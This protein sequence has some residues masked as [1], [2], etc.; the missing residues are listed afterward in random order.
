MPEL[1]WPIMLA[2][3][4]LIRSILTVAAL[5]FL[6]ALL[7]AAA[8]QPAGSKQDNQAP[9]V[10]LLRTVSRLVQISVIATDKSGHPVGDLTSADFVVL[11]NGRREDIRL[12]LEKT[13][14]P[15]TDPAPALPPD[16]YTDR[17]QDVAGIPPS[18][19]ML[20]LDGI[21]T[22]TSDQAYA[23]QQVIKFLQQ[24]KGRDRLAIF[25][26]GRDLHVLQD[27]TDDS[28]KLAAALGKYSGQ[29]TM[30]LEASTPTQLQ[31]GNDSIDA[32]LQ[33]AFQREANMYIQ[34][35]VRVTVAAL[36]EIA[37]HAAALPGRKNLLWVSGSF[38]FSVEYENLQEIARIVNDSNSESNLPGEQ[39]LFV[40]DIERAARA[41]NDA[42]IAVY[43]V[44]ARALLAPNMSTDRSSG[45][46]PGFGAANSGQRNN[47]LT[48]GN[49]TGGGRSPRGGGR[50]PAAARPPHAP[51]QNSSDATTNPI[52][53]PDNTTFE[54]MDAL[55]DGTGGR[56]FYNTN[57]ISSSLRSA[58]D[59]SRL[60]Y[61][62]GY[63][64]NDVKWDGSFHDVT[65]QVRRPDVV[66]RVR[67]GYFALPDSEIKPE[68]LRAIVMNEVSSPLEATAMGVA[69]RVKTTSGQN[70][71]GMSAMVFFDP[72]S[73]HFQFKNG[74][75]QAAVNLVLAQR[76]T[77]N[78]I[79]SAAQQ[80]FPLDFSAV[81]YEQ[82]LKQQVEFTQELALLPDAANL[83]VV[84]CDSTTG[85]TGAVT[86]PLAKYSGSPSR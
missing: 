23:R 46:S 84:L 42:N 64:P 58:I 43:P 4:M 54:T 67:K 38:P 53:N 44:D 19:T 15:R 76:D 68:T 14:Q 30:D 9:S 40:E 39:L 82:F 47:S 51:R 36:I 50:G 78:R 48:G 57:D 20:L 41:L 62:L 75:F 28:S 52:L 61:E 21:N 72:R 16:T 77:N 22:Q 81:Q 7:S 29:T 86:I 63:Y 70:S 35:R 79:L 34:D 33:D 69:V 60:T 74:R 18:V 2:R 83:R 56:A 55:A 73:I 65:I 66:V 32:A 24:I 26:L 25:T 45:K 5:A 71:K 11:D 6:P 59:D 3:R 85:R 17:I 31:T 1:E 8:Q 10:A 80:S 27:F 13:D 49:G 12:F 37:N